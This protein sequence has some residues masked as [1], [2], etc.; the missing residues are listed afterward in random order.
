MIVAGESSASRLRLW[1]HID[2]TAYIVNLLMLDP[3]HTFHTKVRWLDIR[4]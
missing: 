4:I 2:L 1:N 3:V